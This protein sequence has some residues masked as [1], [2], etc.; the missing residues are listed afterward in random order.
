MEPDAPRP[1]PKSIK[2]V[3]EA[4]ACLNRSLITKSREAPSTVNRHV[5][6][7]WGLLKAL[8][9]DF[10]GQ[11]GEVVLRVDLLEP[12]AHDSAWYGRAVRMVILTLRHELVKAQQAR[13]LPPPAMAPRAES[14]G[15]VQH[16]A[17]RIGSVFMSLDRN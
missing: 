3:H 14:A 2:T 4:M 16:T 12:T 1:S 11:L 10:P 17:E 9:A 6:R 15:Q 13:V 7:N 5:K 8:E